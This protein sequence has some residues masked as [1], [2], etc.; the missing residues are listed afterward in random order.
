MFTM[1]YV[2]HSLTLYTSVHASLHALVTCTHTHCDNTQ[3]FNFNAVRTS[4]YPNDP[5]FYDLCDRAGLYVIDEANI[6]THGM[7][8]S[9][10]DYKCTYSN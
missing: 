3:R 9:W 1:H 8:V 10:I 5:W 6:E 7:K 2:V 4:H